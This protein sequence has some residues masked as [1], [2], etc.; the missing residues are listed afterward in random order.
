MQGLLSLRGALRRKLKD[1]RGWALVDAIAS[2]VV[3]VLAFVGTT[4]AFN[5]SEASVARNSKKTQAMIVAQ[6]SINEM[7]GTGQRNINQLLALHD[8]SKTVIYDGVPYTVAYVAEYRTGLGTDQ[9]DACEVSYSSGAGTARYIYMQVRVTYAGQTNGASGSTNPYIS[10]P[11]SLDSY[12]A[13]EG[14]G[15]QADT[16]TLRVYVLNRADG[17]ATGIGSVKL[18]DPGLGAELTPRT[19]NT[20]TGC[21]LFTGLVRNTYTVRVGIS[22]LQDLY[23]T[24]SSSSTV[25]LPVVMPDRGALSREVRIASP[26]NVTPKFYTNT[27]TNSKYEVK[28][29]SGKSNAFFGGSA[30]RLGNWIAAS[31]QIRASTTTDFSYIPSGLAFMP[32]IS[33]ATVATLPNGMFPLKQG[34]S[35]YAGPCDANDPNANAPE[36]DNYQVQVPINLSDGNWTNSIGYSPELWLSQIRTTVSLTPSIKPTSGQSASRTYYFNQTLSTSG[37]LGGAQ[38]WVKLVSDADGGT[39]QPRCISNFNSFD[40]WVRLGTITASGTQL[41]D[42]AEALPVGTYDV[43]VKMPYRYSQAS[44]NSF[45]TFGSTT[46]T[47]SDSTYYYSFP[48]GTEAGE[49]PALSY[50]SALTLGAN[51]NWTTGTVG[52]QQWSTSATP[53]TGQSTDCTA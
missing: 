21:Y 30:T 25:S 22:T 49:I 40:T 39:T 45:G 24:N 13:P 11:A 4:M 46:T 14:G 50:R 26:L 52:S 41:S 29:V 42:E 53:N 31:D 48:H 6:N 18:W 34:Y 7:R 16:G 28:Y 8:T 33:T 3:V 43:C 15:V 51:F 2:S 23:M 35:A 12:Y 27:G 36:T 32:H 19:T 47:S 20:T 37:T 10:S 17:V 44:T 9:Q 1:E 5:G 38:V